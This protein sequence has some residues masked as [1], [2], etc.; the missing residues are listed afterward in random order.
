MAPDFFV[1]LI[2]SG[3]NNSF[4]LSGLPYIYIYPYPY[5]Y[6]YML[7]IF[8]L[9]EVV[10]VLIVDPRSLFWILVKIV[11]PPIQCCIDV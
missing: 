5:P 9:N 3:A 1:R 8:V 7:W 11:D 4:P 6:I 2:F 10:F